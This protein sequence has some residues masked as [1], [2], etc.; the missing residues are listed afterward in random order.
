MKSLLL[1]ALLLLPL[2]VEAQRNPLPLGVDIRVT[3]NQGYMVQ[4]S[5]ATVFNSFPYEMSIHDDV[6]QLDEQYFHIDEIHHNDKYYEFRIQDL[7]CVL[8]Q[9]PIRGWTLMLRDSTYRMMLW[10][11]VHPRYEIIIR[12]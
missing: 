7:Q 2:F 1:W 9:D 8:T 3:L 12:E 5:I 11:K 6:F 4:D 10:E